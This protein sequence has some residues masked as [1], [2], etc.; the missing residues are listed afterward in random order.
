MPEHTTDEQPRTPRREFLLTSAKLAALAGLVPAALEARAASE[1]KAEQPP[2]PANPADDPL[3]GYCGYNCRSCPARSEN[4]EERLKMIEGWN[5]LFGLH[6]TPDKVPGSEPCRGCKSEGPI[7]DELCKARPCAKEKG[8]R[9][10]AECETFGC[11]KMRQL[12]AD[13]NQL[14]LGLAGRPEITK[15]EYERSARQF[16]SVPNLIRILAEK[17][18]LP[19]WVKEY[20]LHG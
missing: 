19:A 6:Y 16:E 1:P 9:S 5:K 3:V 15:E 11:P 2:A 17:G 4:K 13:R 14:L 10:C 18:K 20:Y 12:M 7:A 8:I